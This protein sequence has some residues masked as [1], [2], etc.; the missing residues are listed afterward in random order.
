MSSQRERERGEEEREEGKRK[1]EERKWIQI[2]SI[3]KSH[4]TSTPIA[5][6]WV[7][8]HIFKSRVE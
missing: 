3:Y 1:R 5:L 2:I 4:Y 6:S 8:L 7:S